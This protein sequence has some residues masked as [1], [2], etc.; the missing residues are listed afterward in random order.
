M[1]P[2]I[3]TDAHGLSVS[4]SVLCGD[5]SAFRTPAKSAAAG[6][7]V[8]SI[9]ASSAASSAA[10][11]V[12]EK[13]RYA[14]AS[15]Q[16][17]VQIECSRDEILAEGLRGGK[18]HSA[19][20]A[21]RARRVE[22]IRPAGHAACEAAASQRCHELLEPPLVL[23][24]RQAGDFRVVERRRGRLLHGDELAGIAVVF[25]V[26]QRADDPPIAADPAHAASRSCSSPSTSSGSRRP[27]RWR[28]AFAGNSAA[29]RRS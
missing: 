22:E 14:P 10:S 9:S 29:V 23:L 7:S 4:I 19:G 21:L 24:P 26:G 13:R 11:Y 27:P 2:A 17:T 1:K 8:S 5:C 20:R 12:T 3:N 16:G 18:G 25:H 6:R 15:S 28:R